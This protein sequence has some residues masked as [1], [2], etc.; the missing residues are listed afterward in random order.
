MKDIKLDDACKKIE[1]AIKKLACHFE[2]E[3]TDE[4]SKAKIFCQAYNTLTLKGHKATT[5][6][7]ITVAQVRKLLAH[8]IFLGFNKLNVE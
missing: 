3:V 2:T 6:K 5:E 7:L 1:F 8:C 4:A